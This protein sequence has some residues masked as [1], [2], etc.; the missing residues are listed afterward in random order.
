MSPYGGGVTVT[1]TLYNGFQTANR[2]RQA[3]SQVLAARETCARPSRPCCS[4]RRPP[5]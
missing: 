2:T 3:E 1:Q 4:T 5:T